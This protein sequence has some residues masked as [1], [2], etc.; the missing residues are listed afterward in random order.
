MNAATA[1]TGMS[2]MPALVALLLFFVVVV[3]SGRMM[4]K[5]K[6]TRSPRT[7][8]SRS[9]ASTRRTAKPHRSRRRRQNTFPR[10]LEGGRS[11][12]RGTTC[13]DAPELA[14][15]APEAGLAVRPA[16][17]GRRRLDASVLLRRRHRRH[18]RYRYGVGPPFIQ[19][20]GRPRHGIAPQG[21]FLVLL[22][23]KIRRWE[24][25]TRAQCE[26]MSE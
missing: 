6:R 13:L 1:G 15:C 17:A 7:R 12:G 3:V 2:P 19:R 4:V 11:V 8:T 5:R 18:R 22:L 24:E 16:L 26:R 9:A 23:R 21:T 25:D 20:R 14:V 10:E